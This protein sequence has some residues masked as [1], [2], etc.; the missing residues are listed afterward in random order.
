MHTQDII[1]RHT[2]TGKRESEIGREG[3]RERERDGERE[4]LRE[5]ERE[6]KCACV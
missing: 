6:R 2:C 5:K 1:K 3:E 4:R